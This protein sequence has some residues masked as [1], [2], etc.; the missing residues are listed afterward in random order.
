MLELVW[1]V[2]S[3]SFLRFVNCCIYRCFWEEINVF[4]WEISDPIVSNRDN[5]L[6]SMKEFIETLA[7]NK[8]GDNFE[9]H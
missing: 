8:F 2:K 6:Q 5:S 4:E 7:D 9:W 1:I 3:R